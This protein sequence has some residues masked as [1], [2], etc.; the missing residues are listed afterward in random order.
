MKGKENLVESSKN[1]LGYE[2][3]MSQGNLEPLPLS[4]LSQPNVCFY[5]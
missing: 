2:R 3:P 4:V 1:L 5:S